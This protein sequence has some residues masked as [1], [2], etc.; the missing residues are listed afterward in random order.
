MAADEP[1]VTVRRGVRVAALLPGATVLRGVPHVAGVCTDGGEELRADL[2]VDATGRRT[3]SGTWLADLGGQ[4]PYS[5]AEDRGFVYYSRYFTGPEQPVLRGPALA[6]MGT[7]SLLTLPGDNDTWSVTM[8]GLT[9]DAALKE[10]RKADVFDRVLRAYPLQA[11]W[12]AGQPITDVL[13]MAGVLDRYRRFVVDGRPVV[14]GLA[15]VG[16]AWACT[17]PSAG[18]GLS[19]GLLHAQQLRHAVREHL[20]DPA[21]LAAAFDERTERVVAPYYWNQVAADRERTA[22]MAALREGI[23][24]Q[25]RGQAR[26]A[27]LFTAAGCDADIFRGLLETVLCLAT[28]QEVVARPDIRAKLDRIDVPPA[29]GLPG[30]DRTG[31]LELLAA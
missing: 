23:P 26:A 28:P 3:P 25:A 14:T 7:V 19:V 31:L 27:T 24:V 2:V 5:V 13:P 20:D 1:G 22:E 21:E 17:N 4:P 11:H 29:R 12:L 10:A 30:P 6:P 18:R 9:G 15:A 16:D 8:Y